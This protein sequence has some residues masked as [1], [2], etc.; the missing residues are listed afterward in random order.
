MMIIHSTRTNANVAIVHGFQPLSQYTSSFLLR[1]NSRVAISQRHSDFFV[2]SVHCACAVCHWLYSSG[3]SSPRVTSPM[4]NPLAHTDHS[5][6]DHILCTALE[7]RQMSVFSVGFGFRA[8]AR[9][10]IHLEYF[11]FICYFN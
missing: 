2:S 6:T 11:I 10:A 3:I 1:S 7:V 4:W 5:L 8:V 9:R